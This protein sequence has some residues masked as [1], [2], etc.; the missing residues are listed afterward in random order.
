[1]LGSSEWEKVRDMRVAIRKGLYNLDE[2]PEILEHFLDSGDWKQYKDPIGEEHNYQDDE[3]VKF[4]V[5]DPEAGLGVSYD[6]ITDMCRKDELL[7]VRL[8]HMDNKTIKSGPKGPRKEK[9]FHDN[10]M[11]LSKAE[12][13][14]SQTYALRRLEKQSPKVFKKVMGGELSANAGMIEA[15][16]RKKTAAV[17]LEP[18]K[19]I[20]FIHKHFDQED[21]VYIK[22]RL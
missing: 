18:D 5:S 8:I 3:F 15:G 10:I 12:Q 7:Y 11:K 1:M 21:I 9:R 4:V 17:V 19:V 6:R 20:E 2:F 13:G 14:T 16:F 22:D